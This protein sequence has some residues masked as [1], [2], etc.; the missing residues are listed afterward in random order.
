MDEAEEQGRALK[1]T[2]RPKKLRRI[3]RACDY[4]NKRSIRCRPSEN[5]NTCQNCADFENPCTYDRPAKKRGGQRNR[6]RQSQSAPYTD[7]ISTPQGTLKTVIESH[8][9][10]GVSSFSFPVDREIQ[11]VVLSDPSVII[12]LIEIY[13][14]VVYPMSV[15][16]IIPSRVLSSLSL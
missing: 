8:G 13:F 12:E 9:S 10:E 16:R 7:G 4:C 3:S 6:D 5:P 2:N 14:E 1:D 15:D 11:D